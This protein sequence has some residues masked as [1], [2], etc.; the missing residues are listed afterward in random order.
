VPPSEKIPFY[1][2][3]LPAVS[4]QTT[5]T[6]A[7]TF[8]AR[9]SSFTKVASLP[10][11]DSPVAIIDTAHLMVQFQVDTAAERSRLQKEVMRLEGEIAKA[12]AKLANPN[13]AE[14]APAAVVTQEKERLAAF[15]ATLEKLKPQLDRLKA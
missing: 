5:T 13:F 9:L 15:R 8:L 12:S 11:S 1:T 2:T 6:N 14:R 10:K 7:L 4:D 3:E